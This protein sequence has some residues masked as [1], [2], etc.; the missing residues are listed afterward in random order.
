M[1]INKS[2]EPLKMFSLVRKIILMIRLIPSIFPPIEML[3][4]ST[5]KNVV[6]QIN[7]VFFCVTLVCMLI[8]HIIDELSVNL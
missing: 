8:F 7:S 5:T 4:V 3:F 2:V 1:G 6:S